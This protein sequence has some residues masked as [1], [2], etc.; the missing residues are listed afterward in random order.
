MGMM[1]QAATFSSIELHRPTQTGKPQ[2]GKGAFAALDKAGTVLTVKRGETVFYEGDE[3][4]CYFKVVSG[5]VRSCRLL[6]DG[7]RH[8]GA[9]FF[10]GDFIGINDEDSHLFTAEA[11][12]DTMLIRYSRRSFDTLLWEKPELGRCLLRMVCHGLTAAHEQMLLLGRKTA[13]EKIAS[14]LLMMADR[15]GEADHLVLPMTRADI[16]DYLGLT[17]ET[18]SRAISQL[19]AQ[20]VIALKSASEMAILN[21][22]ALEELAEGT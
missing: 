20:K 13:Q 14:F 8:I 6:A 17:I 12:G 22:E 2:S 3:A 1:L 21:R 11:V 18:V 5:A 7:R 16:G 4:D 9:F 15:G 10:A 19:K